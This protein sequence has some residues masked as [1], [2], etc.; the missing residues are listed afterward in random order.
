[1]PDP[2]AI[3]SSRDVVQMLFYFVCALGFSIGVGIAAFFKLM[4]IP[5]RDGVLDY[6]IHEKK[7]MDQMAIDNS[8]RTEMHRENLNKL[9]EIH[10][11][12]KEIKE[13]I[14][15]P[16]GHGHRPEIAHG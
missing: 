7:F 6:L 15:C 3:A 2:Q 11:L 4:L 14:R 13:K 9:S 8:T 1:M 10:V 5:L 16:P 12:A